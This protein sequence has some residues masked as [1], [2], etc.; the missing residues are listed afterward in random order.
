MPILGLQCTRDLK[1]VCRGMNEAALPVNQSSPG[2]TLIYGWSS[3]ERRAQ[4]VAPAIQG[5][6]FCTFEGKLLR[7]EHCPWCG[8]KIGWS[9]TTVRMQVAAPAPPP[10]PEPPPPAEP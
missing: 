2:L 3:E 1:T 5:I 6:D 7:V 9:P 10:P 4:G 8:A